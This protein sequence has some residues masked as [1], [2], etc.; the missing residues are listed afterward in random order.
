MRL[1]VK[2]GPFYAGTSTRRRRR[3][4]SSFGEALGLL[5][6]LFFAFWPFYL[7]KELHGNHALVW[8]LAILWWLLLLFVFIALLTSKSQKKK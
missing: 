7:G 6:V 1:G 8:S 5:L 4:G 3:G 2:V